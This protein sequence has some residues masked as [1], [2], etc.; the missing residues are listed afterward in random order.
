MV[1]AVLADSKQ[2][3]R[4]IVPKALLRQTAQTL[5][6]KIGDLPGREMKHIPF[7][8]RTP[9]GGLEIRTLH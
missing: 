3:C 6:T 7:S 2:L 9:S 1:V 4:L 8:R 5:Q